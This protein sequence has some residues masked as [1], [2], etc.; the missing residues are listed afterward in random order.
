MKNSKIFLFF[1]Y[2][3]I[4]N[5]TL[6]DFVSVRIFIIIKFYDF[7]KAIFLHFCNIG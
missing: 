4:E 6:E 5:S 1:L 7:I 2:F 3:I